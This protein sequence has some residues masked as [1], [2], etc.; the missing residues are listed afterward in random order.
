L[1]YASLKGFLLA[2]ICAGI[3]VVGLT[4]KGILPG[5]IALLLVCFKHS[6]R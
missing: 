2:F 3:S 4:K 1:V 5:N 6:V